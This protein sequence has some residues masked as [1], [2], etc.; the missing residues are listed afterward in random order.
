MHYRTHNFIEA[1]LALEHV[2]LRL[3][4]HQDLVSESNHGASHLQRSLTKSIANSRS[5]IAENHK[6]RN[7]NPST[8]IMTTDQSMKLH[9]FTLSIVSTLTISLKTETHLKV[10]SY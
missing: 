5:T 3:E 2:S 8:V 1:C 10:V 4:Y 6:M 9:L 7:S